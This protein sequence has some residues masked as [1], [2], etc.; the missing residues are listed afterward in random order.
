MSIRRCPMPIIICTQYLYIAGRDQGLISG[1]EATRVVAS[2]SSIF[3]TI[4]YLTLNSTRKHT[5]IQGCQ[6]AQTHDASHTSHEHAHMHLSTCHFLRTRIT[7]SLKHSLNEKRRVR[8]RHRA[9]DDAPNLLRIRNPAVVRSKH[10]AP[11]LSLLV[12]PL[13]GDEACAMLALSVF[14]A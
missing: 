1:D 9:C 7:G 5:L 11:P 10:D 4:F 12:L 14:F 13:A 8:V 6:T 3:T 2:R